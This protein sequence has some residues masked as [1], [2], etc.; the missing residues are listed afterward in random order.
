MEFLHGLMVDDMKESTWMIKK[1]VKVSSIGPTAE[2]T[3][4]AGKMENNTASEST[5]QLVA[6]PNK[7]NGKKEKGYIG[8]KPINELQF[9]F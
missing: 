2:N 1:K 7:E 4:E 3:K 6:K 5:P 9:N 8:F